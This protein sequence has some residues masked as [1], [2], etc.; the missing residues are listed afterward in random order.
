M[1]RLF[2][3]VFVFLFYAL[4]ARAHDVDRELVKEPGLSHLGFD[5]VA[6]GLKFVEFWHCKRS[7]EHTVQLYTDCTA[8]VRLLSQL[9][10]RNLM[11]PNPV[12]LTYFDTAEAEPITQK[13]GDFDHADEKIDACFETSGHFLG[14]LNYCEQIAGAGSLEVQY[15]LNRPI[16]KCRRR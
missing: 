5:D 10:G 9:L 11:T 4:P 13:P 7:L 3:A 8:R 1:V 15:L 6:F 14:E 2:L 16:P 12:V